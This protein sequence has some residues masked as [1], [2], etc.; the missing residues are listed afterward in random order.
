MKICK[1]VTLALAFSLPLASGCAL[2]SDKVYLCNGE[3]ISYRTNTEFR[4]T[5]FK[6]FSFILRP[7]PSPTA[8]LLGET[9]YEAPGDV[10]SG[11]QGQSDNYRILMDNKKGDAQLIFDLVSKKI[12]YS[13][14]NIY[15]RGDYYEGTCLIAEI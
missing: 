6:D 7:R 14:P 13:S 10:K 5:R 4:T 8:F 15:G 12:T 11:M 3:L 2:Q 9:L 1:T